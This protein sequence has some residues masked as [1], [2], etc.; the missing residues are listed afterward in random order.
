MNDNS[1][2]GNRRVLD[3][4]G[5]HIWND[6]ST[7]ILRVV[8]DSME[9]PS[10]CTRRTTDTI[11]DANRIEYVLGCPY[12]AVTEFLGLRLLLLFCR[13]LAIDTDIQSII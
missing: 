1:C 12:L 4:A 9:H 10:T 13:R 3:D 5:T 6:P 11:D 7:A 2:I 8:G